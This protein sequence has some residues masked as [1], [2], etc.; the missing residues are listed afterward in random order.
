MM[1]FVNYSL[2]KKLNFASVILILLFCG[3]FYLNDGYDKSWQKLKNIGFFD[4]KVAMSEIKSGKGVLIA[5]TLG[6]SNA[7]NSG[8]SLYF[9]HHQLLDYGYGNLYKA[10]D[11]L[12]GCGGQ[13]GS[14]WGYIRR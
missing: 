10:N 11:P 5:L 12:V 8:E 4:Q 6:Q 14:V 9:P 1:K 7:A 2:R 3:V 13:G